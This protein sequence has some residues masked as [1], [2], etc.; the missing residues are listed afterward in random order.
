MSLEFNGCGK[1]FLKENDEQYI[2]GDDF[3]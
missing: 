1:Y 3:K 2:C